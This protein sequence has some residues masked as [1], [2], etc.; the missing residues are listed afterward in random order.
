MVLFY[1]GVIRGVFWVI[2]SVEKFLVEFLGVYKVWLLVAV[3]QITGG[4]SRLAQELFG[5]HSA[6]FLFGFGWCSVIRRAIRAVRSNVARFVAR[7]TN[8]S[9]TF[10]ASVSILMT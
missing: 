9:G 2:F 5:V 3:A 10:I 7:K 4:F 1:V 6:F 8:D